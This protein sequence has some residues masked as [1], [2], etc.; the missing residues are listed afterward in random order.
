[1]RF[2]AL[3]QVIPGIVCAVSLSAQDWNA[4]ALAKGW[5]RQDI[6]GALTFYD[7]DTQSLRVWSKD[8]SASGHLS[9]VQAGV[10]PEYWFLDQYDQAW[11]TSGNHLLYV[12]KAGKVLRRETLPAEVSDLAWDATGFYLVYRLDAVF[13]EK[14]DLKRG[15]VLWSYGPKPKKGATSQLPNLFRLALTG[16]GQLVCTLGPDLNVLMVDS[17]NGKEQGKTFFAYNN[18]PA[19]ALQVFAQDRQPIRWWAQKGVLLA[20]VPGSQMP[21]KAQGQFLAKAD[22]SQGTVEFMATG[23][24][25]G[26][27]L[28]GVL[29]NEATFVKPDGGLVFLQLK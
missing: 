18:A 3:R 9:L 6:T 2:S 21:Q 7:A 16:T 4:Q 28:V 8:G 1:M 13:I 24:D 19:P 12:D 17:G 22:L 10:K 14:R 26:S 15:E 11:L 20:N 27:V 29:D 25:E 5:A 23:L